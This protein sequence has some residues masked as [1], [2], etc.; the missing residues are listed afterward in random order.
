MHLISKMGVLETFVQTFGTIVCVMN[1]ET[2]LHAVVLTPMFL[3]GQDQLVR[4]QQQRQLLVN[5]TP[6]HP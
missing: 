1:E 4:Q 5:P 2:K 3:Q 6:T